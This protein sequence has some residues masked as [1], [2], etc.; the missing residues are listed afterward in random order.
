ML[1]VGAVVAE[2]FLRALAEERGGEGVGEYRRIA[3]DDQVRG[4]C[5]CLPYRLG[6]APSPTASR[7]RLEEL[8]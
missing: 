3:V 1:A 5:S 2:E 4:A 8:G 7:S 6:T